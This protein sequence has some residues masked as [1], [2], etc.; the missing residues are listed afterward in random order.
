MDL[1]A[2]AKDEQAGRNDLAG[3]T[4]PQAGLHR[5]NLVEKAEENKQRN[6]P[7]LFAWSGGMFLEPG[8]V[9]VIGRAEVV[10]DE[11]IG[12][13]GR[14][15]PAVAPTVDLRMAVGERETG[16]EMM[17]ITGQVVKPVLGRIIGPAGHPSGEVAHI[18]AVF[19]H[20]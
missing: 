10:I 12:D 17:I 5:L 7:H 3:T 18:D 8:H 19:A 2:N 20:I 13:H 14:S 16:G 15:G 4:P 6:Y 11:A 1:G 9:W